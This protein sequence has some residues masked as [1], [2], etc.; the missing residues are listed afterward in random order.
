MTVRR[1]PVPASAALLTA[2][3]LGAAAGCAPAGVPDD[4]ASSLRVEV[5]QDRTQY[6][7]GTAKLH[8]TNGSAETLALLAGR[9]QADGF[10]PS[11]LDD[12]HRA[13]TLR[14]GGSH[15]VRI[16]LGEVDCTTGPPPSGTP[17]GD[18][19]AGAVPASVTVALG[20]ADTPGTPAEVALTAT[21]P[22][23]R[24]AAV[25]TQE[26]TRRLVASGA[27]LRVLPDLG[28]ERRR[29]DLVLLLR[30]RVEP[31]PGGPAVEVERITGTT[32]MTPADGSEAWTGDAVVPDGA[33]DITLDVV[34]RRCDPHA[35]AED[36]RGTFTP[37]LTM[38]DGVEQPLLHLPLPEAAQPA[39]F[40]Y[41]SRA[42]AWDR[43][44][45][46]PGRFLDRTDRGSAP[47]ARPLVEISR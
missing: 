36:K 3:A 11:S 14:P 29:D 37:V 16:V 34:P 26:C 42:C 32:L 19:G 39:F 30:V 33:G 41:V 45:A 7:A 20:E 46:R 27:T 18:D 17:G 5:R 2:V 24:L 31:V 28:T 35:V 10:G 1:G 13:R 38:V 43:D 12:S 23:G 22:H 15:D 47:G 25:H 40:D 8:V 44:D 4:V 6:A 9:L 21:D